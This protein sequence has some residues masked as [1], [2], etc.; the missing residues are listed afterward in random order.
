MKPPVVVVALLFAILACQSNIRD[1]QISVTNVDTIV[2]DIPKHK[3]GRTKIIYTRVKERTKELGL[4]SI[5]NGYDSLEVRI[6]FNYMSRKRA[7]VNSAP[8]ITKMGGLSHRPSANSA[9][10]HAATDFAHAH[11]YHSTATRSRYP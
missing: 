6:W 5:E 1:S 8:I 4:N 7:I 3:D 9:P 10:N 11:L 2:K